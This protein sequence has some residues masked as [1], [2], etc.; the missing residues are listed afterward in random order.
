MCL[1]GL[2]DLGHPLCWSL[3]FRAPFLGWCLEFSVAW[4]LGFGG[5]VFSAPVVGVYGLGV[6]GLRPT[7]GP[8]EC[9]WPNGAGTWGLGL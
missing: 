7:A 4:P 8:Y 6:Q 2:Q 5:L 1:A 3:G 9:L